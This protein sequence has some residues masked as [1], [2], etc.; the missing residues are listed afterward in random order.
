MSFLIV[1]L[2]V[3][4][5]NITQHN[6]LSYDTLHLLLLWFHFLVKVSVLMLKIITFSIIMLIVT[7]H[8]GINSGRSLGAT[9]FIVILSVIM[10]SVVR[11][12][13]VALLPR[14][15]KI[16]FF[17]NFFFWNF[18]FGLNHRHP[19][20]FLI[21]R[22]LKDFNTLTIIEQAA[23]ITSEDCFTKHTNITTI[24]RRYN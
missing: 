13:V 19:K 15:K 2:S 11:P 17:K 18:S 22:K 6:G 14:V 7:Q 8:Y 23:S 9:F 20:T 16:S 21:L 24:Y 12:N 4:G 3:F 5:L 10:L 1:F